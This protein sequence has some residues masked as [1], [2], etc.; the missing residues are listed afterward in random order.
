MESARSWVESQRRS[1]PPFHLAPQ[2]FLILGGDLGVGKSHAAAWCVD[3]LGGLFIPMADVAARKFEGEFESELIRAR[4]LAL[5][6]FG[7]EPLDA[8]GWQ[9]AHLERVLRGRY[10]EQRPT[11]IT[12]NVWAEE[13]KER[14]GPRVWDRVMAGGP[15][16]LVLCEGENLRRHWAETDH[17]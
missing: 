4:C 10:S 9:E 12:T 11:L 13:L 7:T 1:G 15:E 3:Q 14:I 8:G 5:D 17:G 2:P 16:S 6:D